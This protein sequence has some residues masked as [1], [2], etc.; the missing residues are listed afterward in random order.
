MSEIWVGGM[1]VIQNYD[2]TLDIKTFKNY[3]V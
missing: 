2:S 1:T 3:T